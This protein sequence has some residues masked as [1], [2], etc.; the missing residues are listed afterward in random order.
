MWAHSQGTA[1]KSGPV[2]QADISADLTMPGPDPGGFS[3]VD[4]GNPWL[5]SH[6]PVH[7]VIA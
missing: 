5:R 6:Q 1:D 3:D 2:D 4:T 7:G